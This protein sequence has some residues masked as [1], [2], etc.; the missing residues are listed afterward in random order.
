MRQALLALVEGLYVP[1]LPAIL[2]VAM[3]TQGVHG[4]RHAARVGRHGLIRLE[5]S[6]N[7]FAELNSLSG[8]DRPEAPR[9]ARDVRELS[10]VPPMLHGHAADSSRLDV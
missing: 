9:S 10:R 3:F 2:G 1:A 7:R 6:L 4:Y 5:G 8:L